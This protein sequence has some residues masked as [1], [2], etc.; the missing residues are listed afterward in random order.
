[1]MYFTPRITSVVRAPGRIFT[2]M[3]EARGAAPPLPAAMPATAVPWPSVSRLGTFP[4][5]MSPAENSAPRWDQGGGVPWPDMSHSHSTRVFP[6]SVRNSGWVRSMPES[7]I[8]TAVPWPVRP[9][10]SWRWTGVMQAASRSERSTGE[11]R[12]AGS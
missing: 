4:R 6:V 8:P 12:S 3:R 1:M 5:S 7:M 2:I 11:S 10:P 9:K